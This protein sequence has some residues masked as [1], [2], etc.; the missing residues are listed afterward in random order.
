VANFIGEPPVN[1]LAGRVSAA[2]SELHVCGAGWSV[3]VDGEIA[4][5]LSRALDADDVILGIRPEHVVVGRDGSDERGIDGRFF[6]RETRGDVD[7]LLVD[8]EAPDAAEPMR[9]SVETPGPMNVRAGDIASLRFP[10]ERLMFFDARSGRNV[11]SSVP[12]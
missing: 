3:A 12:A 2:G 1:L 7:V 10:A 8:L 6:Y 4:A 9:L 5:R 11:L